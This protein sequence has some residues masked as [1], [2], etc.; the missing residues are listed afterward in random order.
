VFDAVC[1][2][3]ALFNLIAAYHRHPQ[4]FPKFPG[5]S[6][7][8]RSRPACNDDALWF[9]VHVSGLPVS[10]FLLKLRDTL[11]AIRNAKATYRSPSF[12]V[13]DTQAK[14]ARTRSQV[15]QYGTGHFKFSD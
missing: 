2:D 7:F 5:K 14:V 10:K 15:L 4:T 8:S 9:S 12:R 6:S 1:V 3:V 11:K 13:S